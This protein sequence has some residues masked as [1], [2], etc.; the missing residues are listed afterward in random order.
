M[1]NLVHVTL[2]RSPTTGKILVVTCVTPPDQLPTKAMPPVQKYFVTHVT[3][4]W[5]KYTP[6]GEIKKS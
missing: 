5:Q 3:N 2:R 4:N 1:Y 6:L